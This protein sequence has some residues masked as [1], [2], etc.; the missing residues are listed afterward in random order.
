[1]PAPEPAQPAPAPE[2]AAPVA[3]AEIRVRHVLD[4]NLRSLDRKEDH[5]SLIDATGA[6]FAPGKVPAGTYTIKTSFGGKP[7]IRSGTVYVAAG[8]IV[9]VT[10]FARQDRCEAE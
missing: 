5:S 6:R 9:V 2:P 1:V 4:K 7:E 10:C 8:G 3:N